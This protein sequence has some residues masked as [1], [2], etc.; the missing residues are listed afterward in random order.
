M[1]SA[2]HIL[3]LEIFH[4]G[5]HRLTRPGAVLADLRR[6]KQFSNYDISDSAARQLRAGLAHGFG[7]LC[8]ALSI[9]APLFVASRDSFHCLYELVSPFSHWS[10]FFCFNSEFRRVLRSV[11]AF[12]RPYDGLDQYFRVVLDVALEVRNCGL[13]TPVPSAVKHF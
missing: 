3:G 13:G 5:S 9:N 7:P 2:H 1:C 4:H 6:G 10:G 11:T 8:Q 12:V